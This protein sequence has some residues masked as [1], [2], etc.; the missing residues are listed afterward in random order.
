MGMIW[1]KCTAH[2]KS[3]QSESKTYPY[4][5]CKFC[6]TSKCNAPSLGLLLLQL[7]APTMLVPFLTQVAKDLVL[8]DDV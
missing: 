4:S 1:C 6:F 8:R 3:S 7:K 2:L 5:T